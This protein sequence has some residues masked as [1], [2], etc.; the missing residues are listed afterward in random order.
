MLGDF[1]KGAYRRMRSLGIRGAPLEMFEAQQG[2]KFLREM[3]YQ[4][5]MGQG[6]PGG[7]QAIKNNYGGRGWEG[8][9]EGM[10]DYWQGKNL[11]RTGPVLET[12]TEAQKEAL[13]DAENVSRFY[14]RAVIGTA[15][16]VGVGGALFGRDS[17]IPSTGKAAL[18]AGAVSGISGGLFHAAD[19]VGEMRSLIKNPVASGPFGSRMY[20]RGIKGAL[21]NPFSKVHPGVFR[22]AGVGLI[23]WTAYNLLRSGDNFG[24]G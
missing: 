4:T 14:R 13:L 5:K 21:E 18:T 10:T 15:A 9:K 8:V 16:A 11:S 1:F 23:G 6:M 20:R 19:K 3:G 12:M 17:F 7:F 22:A 2:A 24:P